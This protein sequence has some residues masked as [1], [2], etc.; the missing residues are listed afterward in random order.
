VAAE[1]GG[2]EEARVRVH[3]LDLSVMFE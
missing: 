1:G 3:L 2:R